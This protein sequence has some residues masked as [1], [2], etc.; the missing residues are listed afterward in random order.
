MTYLFR[1]PATSF[2]APT[3]PRSDA[4]LASESRTETLT[5]QLAHRRLRS[6]TPRQDSHVS[7]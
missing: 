1:P 6:W 5:Q 2:A 3:A 4:A 7:L